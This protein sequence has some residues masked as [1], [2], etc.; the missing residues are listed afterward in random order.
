MGDPLTW[1]RAVHFAATLTLAGALIFGAVV[2]APALRGAD[3]HAG[4]V[5]VWSRLLRIAWT[6][7]ALAVVSGA[8]W[9][10][11]LAAR[12]SDGP[13]TEAFSGGPWATVLLHTTFGH[14]WLVR[15]AFAALLAVAL[16]WISSKRVDRSRWAIAAVLAVVFAA[17]LVHSGHAAA[18][19][20][21]LGSF[22]RAADGL[23]LVAASAWLGGLLPLAVL[24]AAAGRDEIAPAV[25]RAVTLRFSTL[26]VISVATLL[27]TGTVNG[28]LLAGSVPALIGT[29]YGRLL[30]IKVALF[31]VM[32]A[33][34]AV[35]R[36]RLTPRL[37]LAKEDDEV[38][39]GRKA[40]HALVRNS[41]IETT[42]GL[43]I[44]VLVGALGTAPPGAHVQPLWPL[45][46]RYSDAAFDDPELR[47]KLVTALWAI[48][49]GVLLGAGLILGGV[50]A[51]RLSWLPLPR[52]RAWLIAAGSGI[53]IA[54]V[55]YFAPT[56]RLATVEAYPTSFHVSPTGY[57]ASSIVQGAS[58][59]ATHC[60]SCHGR[61]GRGDGP[62]GR[63]FR[64]K[65]SDL[66]ADHVYAHS[67]GD[68]FWWITHG[69][70]EVMPP[71]GAVLADEA[72]WNVIDFVRANADA[73]RL[74]QA[75]GKVTDIAYRMPDFSAACPDGSTLWR[76]DLRGRIAH[77][78]IAGRGSAA[79]VAEL[80]T[81]DRDVVTIAIPIDDV[82]TA[83]A[84]RTDDAALAKAL[85]TLHAGTPAQSEG[86]EAL[87]DASGAL[88]ALWSPGG[89]PDWRD[90]EVL[91]REIAAIRS[92]PVASR[93]TGSHLH[94]H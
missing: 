2:A 35:N 85:A 69:I 27:A 84:C 62:A 42:F 23:H 59:F 86:I 29:D 56:L 30:V 12:M 94:G 64:V 24:L 37:M 36:L 75:H 60:A 28:W 87:V 5:A 54:C 44:L 72:R 16:G 50:L 58:L 15:L 82:A 18:T 33:I 25:A 3:G 7:W 1:I 57:S 65:P 46:L 17:A 49:G 11:L 41:A 39:A 47:G 51:R 32:V 4:C 26:G 38:A 78:V 52:P 61:Q 83:A 10:V 6:G 91:Q 8:A 92:N 20:G 90:D 45:A 76:D 22:H 89:K 80:A 34:A 67:D 70:R 66:A 88:R 68:L 74:R 31:L 77:L 21:W 9:L 93:T 40:L 81:H 13:P 63:F 71:F 19:A 14:A 79:R 55:A 48:G 53:A 73:T 43:A